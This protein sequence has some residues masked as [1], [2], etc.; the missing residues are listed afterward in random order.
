MLPFEV[1]AEVV[2]EL[3]ELLDLLKLEVFSFHSLNLQL[4][5]LQEIFCNQLTSVELTVDR[6]LF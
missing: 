5:Y 3:L 6:G 4:E 2:V 1:A